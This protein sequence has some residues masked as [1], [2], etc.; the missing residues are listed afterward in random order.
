MGVLVSLVGV[1]ISFYVGML[2]GGMIVVIVVVVFVL[3]VVFSGLCSCWIWCWY[4][5][6]EGYYVYEYGERCG[7]LVVVYDGYVDYLYGDWLY[8]FYGGYY[9]EYDLVYDLS[10]VG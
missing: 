5:I 7:H 4:C 1:S 8:V 6:V 9:D 3:I 2:F 10:E